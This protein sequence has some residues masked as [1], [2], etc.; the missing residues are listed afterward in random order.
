[1]ARRFSELNTVVFCISRR[2]V[3]YKSVA[4]GLQPATAV[5]AAAVDGV[6]GI[7]AHTPAAED[8]P[9]S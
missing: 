5:A 7:S 6:G 2:R 4:R 1:M 9:G 3:T 8:L